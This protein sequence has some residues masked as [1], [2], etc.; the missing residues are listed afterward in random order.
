MTRKSNESSDEEPQ[1]KN[2]KHT[3]PIDKVGNKWYY[4]QHQT[5]RR[6]DNMRSVNSNNNMMCM[7]MCRML[8]SQASNM[9]GCMAHLSCTSIH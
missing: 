1:Q 9:A 5:E 2:K 8:F 6:Y 3:K 7:C 4:V